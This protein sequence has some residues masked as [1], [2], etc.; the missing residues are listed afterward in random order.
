MTSLMRHYI[1]IYK[2][3]YACIIVPCLNS[4]S[5]IKLLKFKVKS[6]FLQIHA[7]IFFEGAF[8]GKNAEYTEYHFSKCVHES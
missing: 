8:D 2:L 7:K 1:V 5:I 3:I 6:Q 4:W